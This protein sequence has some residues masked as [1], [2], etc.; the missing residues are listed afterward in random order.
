M[1]SD[2][3]TDGFTLDLVENLVRL[4]QMLKGALCIDSKGRHQSVRVPD[5]NSEPSPSVCADREV[6][7]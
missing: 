7:R 6:S 5:R 1:A 2:N 3:D 4:I